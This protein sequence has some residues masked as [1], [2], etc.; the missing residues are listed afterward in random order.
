VQG[1]RIRDHGLA[2]LD[3]YLE[4]FADAAGAR[5]IQ[6]HWAADG[7]A[8]ISQI[9]EIA[10]HNRVSRVIKSKSMVTEEIH[11]NDALEKE[12]L[13]V[14]ETDLGE[15][16]A[17]LSGQPP[18]HI[19]APVVHMSKEQVADLFGKHAQTRM[20]QDIPTLTAYA[21]RELRQR[22]L[23]A[24]MG[25]SGA[26]FAIAETGSIVL[27]TNEGNG[28]FVTG[29]P[30]V[31]VALM[32]MEKVVPTWEDLT[33]L[34]RL[35]TRSATGQRI[36]SYV[37][38]ITGPRQAGEVDG[39]DEVHIVILDNGRSRLLGTK[40]QESLRCIRCGACLNV[41]PVYH[42]VGGHTYDAT[43]SG[44]I[45]SIQTPLLEGLGR[46]H[47]LPHA[48]SLCFACGEVCPVKIDLPKLLLELRHDEAEGKQATVSRAERWSF[49]LFG[50]VLTKPFLYRLAVRA[51]KIAQRP[52][53]RGES[54]SSAPFPL[55]QWTRV[56]DL[57][58]IRSK[59]FRERWNDQHKTTNAKDG[60]SA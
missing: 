43:Y 5:G 12:G 47:D 31:H 30:R 39:P 60:G 7:A 13:T 26:N 51:G 3:Q 18:S 35:L 1:Q 38:M 24:D 22:F 16:I 19:I 49:R 46:Y 6:V 8:A 48:S 41:C 36:S 11:L 54:I 17:Q 4:Q 10:K 27:V 44:P 33:I 2:H 58:P 34:L 45:G 40:Y 53:V 20:T 59:T 37:S 50:W 42:E 32:G 29:L 14:T 25:I 55:S 28:R 9:L 21:R 52:F 57:P 15:W 23:D 56:R